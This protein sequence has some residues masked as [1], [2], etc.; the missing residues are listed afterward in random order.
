MITDYF[1]IV[2]N[3]FL[4]YYLI[5]LRAKQFEVFN[6]SFIIASKNNTPQK[7]WACREVCQCKGK[8]NLR[9]NIYVKNS[10]FLK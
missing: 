8:L 4:G 1:K 10:S 2:S 6:V 9:D 3:V 5:L 7:R